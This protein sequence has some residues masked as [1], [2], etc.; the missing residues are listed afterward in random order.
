MFQVEI[1][2]K[3]SKRSSLQLNESPEIP[4]TVTVSIANSPNKRVRTEVQNTKN[5]M[6]HPY[7]VFI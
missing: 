6:L 5:V 4:H 2:K 1:E 3:M 7:P